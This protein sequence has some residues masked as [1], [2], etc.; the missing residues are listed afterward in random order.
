[1][2]EGVRCEDCANCQ[3]RPADDPVLDEWVCAEGVV[4][5]ALVMI[6]D[7]RHPGR[8]RAHENLTRPRE[9]AFYRARAVAFPQKTAQL[10]GT[11]CATV[12]VGGS[13]V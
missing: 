2:S 6:A 4:K 1:M 12:R 3:L 10:V 7:T 9:C 8:L 13:I 5:R 11:S